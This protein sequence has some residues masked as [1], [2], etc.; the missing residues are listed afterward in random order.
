[1]PNID[2]K[3][4]ELRLVASRET[5]EICCVNV[6]KLTTMKEF[7]LGVFT[8]ANYLGEGMY[9]MVHE[10]YLKCQVY[11]FPEGEEFFMVMG[12]TRMGAID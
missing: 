1:M 5:G 11:E 2:V 9:E 7:D 6:R 12:A 4:E 3:K 10:D 8:R